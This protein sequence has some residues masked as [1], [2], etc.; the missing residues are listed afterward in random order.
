MVV[1]AVAKEQKA[2]YKF[3]DHD[4]N[5]QL[6]LSFPPAT[7]PSKQQVALLTFHIFKKQVA[8]VNGLISR[9]VYMH[10]CMFLY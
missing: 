3:D 9:K 5:Y 4:L 6:T 7:K 1:V 2:D 10:V 8:L